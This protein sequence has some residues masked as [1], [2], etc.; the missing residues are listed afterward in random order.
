MDT[1]KTPPGVGEEDEESTRANAAEGTQNTQSPH[2]RSRSQS[3]TQDSETRGAT[4]DPRFQDMDK[5]GIDIV[6]LDE[7]RRGGPPVPRVPT[8]YETI[9]SQLHN[10]VHIRE[11]EV[12]GANGRTEQ[13]SVTTLFIPVASQETT[14]SE[15]SLIH[16]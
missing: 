9:L 2:D 14:D 4:P 3:R 6:R 16:I 1:R 12:G 13:S 5:D 11:S 15:L 8:R 10:A 7:E